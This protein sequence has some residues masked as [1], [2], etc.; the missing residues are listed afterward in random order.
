MEK[1]H[2]ILD[3]LNESL[4]LEYSL[5]IHYPLINRAIKDPDIKQMVNI[6]GVVSIKHADTVAD[7]ITALGGTPQWDFE[8]A[9]DEIDLKKIFSA[10]LEK[11]KLALKLHSDGAH[12]ALDKTWRTR[13]EAMAKQ[14]VEHIK[15]VENILNLIDQGKN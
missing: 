11:E 13:F 3:T 5:I 1:K 14:E 12:M 7:A 2:Q 9:P 8:P 6:L 15:L 10:Q 4:R